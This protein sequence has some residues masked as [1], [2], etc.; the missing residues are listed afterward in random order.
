[1]LKPFSEPC[2][3]GPIIG[4]NINC[5]CDGIMV[6]DNVD[7]PSARY[8]TGTCS[9]CKCSIYNHTTNIETKV[10][11]ATFSQLSWAIPLK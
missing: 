11:C 7:G 4:K 1:M 2:G 3:F 10:D 6:T 5:L 9:N 8:C